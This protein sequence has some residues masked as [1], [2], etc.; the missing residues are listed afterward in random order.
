MKAAAMFAVAYG[1][2]PSACG[3]Q[4]E[5]LGL[6]GNIKTALAYRSALTARGVSACFSSEAGADLIKDCGA[7]VK[8]I[9]RM[10]LDAMRAKAARR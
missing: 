10:K 7:P 5:M 4:E 2:P 8:D 9:A 1:F 6:F 3:S